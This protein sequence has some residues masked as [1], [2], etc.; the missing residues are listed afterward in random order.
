M[1]EHPLHK[2]RWA[3]VVDHT[4]LTLVLFVNPV[5][6]PVMVFQAPLRSC[7]NQPG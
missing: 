1:T 5:T 4:T 6:T 2:C 7:Q 3:T